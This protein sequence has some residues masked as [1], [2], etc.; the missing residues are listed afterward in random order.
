MSR[1]ENIT[2]I[3][4]VY[5]ALEDLAPTCVF[6]GGATVD[7][8]SERP[9]SEVR[10]TEDVDVLIELMNYHGYAHIEERLRQKGFVNDIES[11]VICRYRLHGIIVDIMPT[12]SRV[13]GFSNQWYT[14]G[15]QNAIDFQ[16]D[17]SHMIK[18]LRPDYFMASKVEAFRDRGKGDGRF[19]TDFEDIVYVLNARPSIYSEMKQAP[20]QLR[21][22][23]RDHFNELLAHP[24]LEE[25]I[26]A[27]LEFAEQ[28]KISTIIGGLQELVHGE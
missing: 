8:Y 15:Y 13:L 21:V 19:S 12:D 27:H 24:Y 20:E 17:D 11:G 5:D 7:L 2:R 3:K 10:P 6:V 23:L 28:R 22:F 1:Q 9:A 25:W 16:L 14:E 18:I 4:A 26:S